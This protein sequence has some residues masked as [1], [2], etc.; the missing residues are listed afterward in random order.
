MVMSAMR[1]KTKLIFFLVLLAFVG[2]VFFD[3]GMQGGGGKRN[4]GPTG[5]E[6]G[7]VNGV[8]ISSDVYLRT[9]QGL[10]DQFEQ[11]RGSAPETADFD[12]IDDETWM[13]VVRQAL[14]DQE[15][16]KYG[17]ATNDPE[18]VEIL[19]NSP[20]E[21]VRSAPVFQNETGQF[22][23]GRYQQALS[24]PNFDWLPVEQY[25]KE[26]LPASKLE[27]FVALNARVTKSEVMARFNDENEKVRVRFVAAPSPLPG[28]LTAPDDAKIRAYYDAHQDD[29]KTGERAT[30]EMVRFPKSATPEDSAQVREDLADVRRMIVEEK[31]DFADL[32]KTWS[33]DPSA[34]RGGDLGFFAKGDMVPEFENVAFSLAPGQVSEPFASPFGYHVVRVE[35][36]KTEGGVEKI[37]ASHILMKVEPSSSTERA[38]EKAAEDFLANVQ[39][40]KSFADA[41]KEA[42]VIIERTPAFDRNAFIPG[43]GVPRAATRFAFS[44][45]VGDTRPEFLEDDRGFVAIR[46]AE[47][48]PAGTRPLEEVRADAERLAADAERKEVARARLTDALANGGG[49]LEGVAKAAGSVVD[50]VAAFSKTTFVPNIGRRNEFVAAAFSLPPGKLSGVIETDRGAYVLDVVERIPADPAVMSAQEPQIR[51]TLLTEKRRNFVTSWLEQILAKAEIVDLRGGQSMPWKPDAAAFRYV[52]PSA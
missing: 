32:A 8:G 18:I 22:D 42:G 29:F 23:P 52:K 24:D 6:I 9:R 46:L 1:E 39:A 15:I 36:K 12:A 48:I 44:A 10:V 43:L 5:N 30:L 47:K 41:A 17:I 27:N 33:E 35:E 40:G 38:Q 13:T 4:N 50:T 14:I 25:L 20:P 51:Q 28:E 31:K 11:S 26:T 16:K 21:F 2:L 3:W 45:K 19:R 37:R 7:R 49:T 34:E